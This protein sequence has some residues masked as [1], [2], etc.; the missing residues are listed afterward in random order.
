MYVCSLIASM[1]SEQFKIIDLTV[2]CTV[3]TQCTVHVWT[4]S[5]SCTCIH[6]HMIMSVN[7]GPSTH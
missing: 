4:H 2:V 1:V 3:Q 5:D 7:V 6:F